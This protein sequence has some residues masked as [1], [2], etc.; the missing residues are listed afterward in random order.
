VTKIRGRIY[1]KKLVIICTFL[2]LLYI[3]PNR[4]VRSLRG[5]DPQLRSHRF[6]ERARLEQMCCGWLLRFTFCLKEGDCSCV[7]YLYR[8]VHPNV[9]SCCELYSET[10]MGVSCGELLA[11]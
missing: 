6:G 9:H 7:L 3:V 10:L 1:N 4:Q 8:P 5:K 2:S 11:I